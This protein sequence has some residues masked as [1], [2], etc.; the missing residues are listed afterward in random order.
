MDPKFE[1]ASYV[2]GK[3]MQIVKLADIW[4][5]PGREMVLT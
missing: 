1:L 3:R 2:V 5:E 4:A